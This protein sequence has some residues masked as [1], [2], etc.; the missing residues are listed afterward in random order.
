M[1][2]QADLMAKSSMMGALDI[3]KQLKK[4]D[5]AF[6]DGKQVLDNIYQQIMRVGSVAKTYDGYGSGNEE[7]DYFDKVMMTCQD[8]LKE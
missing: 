7:E 6:T 8:H 2:F 3:D 1:Q 5:V 4:F